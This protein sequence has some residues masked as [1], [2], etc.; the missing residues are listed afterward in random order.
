[1]KHRIEGIRLQE[2][3]TTF[4][5]ELEKSDSSGYSGKELLEKEVLQIMRKEGFSKQ[6]I[7]DMPLKKLLELFY[8]AY[9]WKANRI[10]SNSAKSVMI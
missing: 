7:Y 9:L 3:F 10:I 8:S 6:Q 4:L 1:M 2:T 5:R